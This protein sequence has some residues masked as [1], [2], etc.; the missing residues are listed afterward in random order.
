MAVEP[1]ES[2]GEAKTKGRSRRREIDY[3][4]RRRRGIREEAVG[5]VNSVEAR[6]VAVVALGLALGVQKGVTTGTNGI[7]GVGSHSGIGRLVEDPMEGVLGLGGSR[8]HTLA[9][10]KGVEM[11]GENRTNGSGR[12]SWICSG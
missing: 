8:E 4:L 12:I 6:E 9:Y 3:F 5:S 1:R 11:G 2:G 7:L 10:L